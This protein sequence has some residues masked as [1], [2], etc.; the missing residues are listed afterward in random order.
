MGKWGEVV[1]AGDLS[2]GAACGPVYSEMFLAE[3]QAGRHSNCCNP[4]H[5]HSFL[6]RAHSFSV[7]VAVVLDSTGAGSPCNFHQD[8]A[9]FR[10]SF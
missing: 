8:G 1:L 2:S 10:E 9:G 4:E 6:P 7:Q 3:G 5:F